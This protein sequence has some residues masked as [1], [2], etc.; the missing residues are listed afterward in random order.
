MKRR[1]TLALGAATGAALALPALAQQASP[2]PASSSQRVLRYAFVAAET[3]FDPAQLNDVYSIT[4]TSHIF[5]ALYNYDHLARPPKVVPLVAAAMPEI[6]PDFKVWTIRIQS[7]IFF[8]DDPA[9]GG[10]KRELTAEDFVYTF[11][12][13]ADPANKSPNWSTLEEQQILGL[14]EVREQSLATRKPFDYD[15]PIEGLRALDRYTLQFK[16]AASRPRLMEVLAATELYGAVAREVVQKYGDTIGAH[17]VGTGPYRLAEWRRSSRIVLERNP[18]YRERLWQAEP[19][20]DD[21]AGQAIAA[22]LRGRRIPLIDRVEIAIIEEPQPRWLSFLNGQFDLLERVP[23]SFISLAMPGGKIAPNLAKQGIKGEIVLGTD[24]VMTYFNM[25]DP[26]VGGYAPHQVAL[27]RAIGLAIDLEREIKVL[28]RGMAIP[29]QSPIVPFTSGYDP[30][31][32][33][34]NSEYNPARAKALLDLYGY[35]DR[36]GDGWREM[37]DGKPLVLL[38]ATQATQ[39]SREQGDLLQKN[40]AAVGL[41]IEFQPAQWP[42]NLKAARAGKLM[43]WGVAASASGGDGQGALTYL[44]GP[45]S[46]EYNLARFKLPAFDAVYD[47]LT[48][49]PDGPERDALFVQAKRLAVAYMPYKMHCHRLIAD[50][51]VKRLQ[52]YR[53]PAYWFNWW[54]MVDMEMS[55]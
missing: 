6:T 53:R 14:A 44:Y 43:M 38:S 35:T 5:E 19:A 33:S 26:V 40:L 41:K 45:Q 48:Q 16:L 13:F 11:K 42:E 47:Q 22:R 7:G 23:A 34:E 49:V 15:R 25:E 27:R 50:V 51:M 32:K 4:V 39:D 36:N 17:P 12:R 31:F 46:G 3:N 9:F 52:G 37:P 21:A 2:P 29:A 1:Q 55:A 24:A 30:R 8:A 10:K 28:R 18:A 54:H 20:A